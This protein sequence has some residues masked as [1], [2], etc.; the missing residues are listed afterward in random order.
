M[1]KRAFSLIELTIAIAII[2]I[3]ASVVAPNAFRA[4][5]KAKVARA[6]A[7]IKAIKVAALAFYR[8]V[9]LFPG[10]QWGVMPPNPTTGTLYGLAVPGDPF[11]NADYGKGFVDSPVLRYPA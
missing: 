1:G 6:M 4:I 2:S 3:L 5:E 9:G 7:D 11:S 10:S 8:D